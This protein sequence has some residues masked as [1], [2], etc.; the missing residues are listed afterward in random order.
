[1]YRKPFK[2]FKN[3]QKYVKKTSKAVNNSQNYFYNMNT[4]ENACKE[5][6]QKYS[7]TF[8]NS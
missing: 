4:V 3:R 7:K 1:M 2:T 6:S 8:K 5:D